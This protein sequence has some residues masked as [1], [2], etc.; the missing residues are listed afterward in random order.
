MKVPQASPSGQDH[1]VPVDQAVLA[2][3]AVLVLVPAPVAAVGQVADHQ[4]YQDIP[5]VN[6]GHARAVPLPSHEKALHRLQADLAL[7]LAE[8]L[9]V[10]LGQADLQA[11]VVVDQ[12]D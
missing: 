6:G 4:V 12:V 5:Q 7:A 11:A 2:A 8:V 3:L 9:L 10:A 1:L